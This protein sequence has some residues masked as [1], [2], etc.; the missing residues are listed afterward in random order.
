MNKSSL[1]VVLSALTLSSTLFAA[2]PKSDPVIMNIGPDKVRLS[3]FEYLYNK[4]NSQQAADIP[5][6]EYLDMFVNYKLKVLAARDAGLDT[7]ATYLNDMAKYT[8]DLSAPYLRCKAV[9]DSLVNVAYEHMKDV[10]DVDHILIASNHSG[11]TVEQLRQRADSVRQALVDGADFGEMAANFSIDRTTSAN[12][13]K[14]GNVIGGLWPYTF[15]DLVYTTPVGSV[16]KVA[17][18]PYGFHIVRVNSRHPNPGSVKARHIL[19]RTDGQ[20]DERQKA[21]TDSLLALLKNG[22]DFATLAAEYTQDP[23]GRRS[24]GDLPWFSEGQMV[25]DFSDAAFA[26]K[27][28]EIS[29]PV[30]TSY[31]WHIIKLE[32]RKPLM[33]L[34]SLRQG[35]QERIAN[36]E[37]GPMAVLRTLDRWKAE[38]GVSISADA[39]KEFADAL[40]KYS[41]S[42]EAIKSLNQSTVTAARLGNET[43]TLG[44]V[45]RSIR[46]NPSYTREQALSAYDNALDGS[47][48]SLARKQFIESLPEHETAYRNLLNEYRDGL[49]LYEI[50]NKEVWDR[51]N[52]DTEGLEKFYEAHKAD[53]SWDRPRFKGYLVSATNDSVADAAMAFLEKNFSNASQ[54][55]PSQVLKK[56]FGNNAKIERALVAKGDNAII[57]ALSFGGPK[58]KADSR[59]KAFRTFHGRVINAP[60]EARDVKGQVSLA[61]QQE[62]EAKWLE[63]LHKKYPVKIDRKTIKK[64]V[65]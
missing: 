58:P 3:E 53:Y 62:L 57:D 42:D 1:A 21:L 32:Q 8:A 45:V 6:D 65:H 4:N 10:A 38:N 49:L 9:D 46:Q 48:Y 47:L 2:K 64:A 30:R 51:A 41:N 14:M 7:L 60:E 23:Q 52:S 35:I 39:R 40:T 24:G 17:Q 26:M 25:K 31:G 22:A 43:I 13:G 12:G 27:P 56:E 15:E 55:I 34:D 19:R 54:P 18:S 50:S 29:E 20:N 16:S 28:G 37:R 59:W 5:I 63:E 33:P 44:N 61:Y 36:D 11:M